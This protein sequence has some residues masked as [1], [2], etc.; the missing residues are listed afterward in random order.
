MYFLLQIKSWLL[1]PSFP[2]QNV[3]LR[4]LDLFLGLEPAKRS[5]GMP[6]TGGPCSGKSECGKCS[7]SLCFPPPSCICLLLSLVRMTGREK[8]AARFPVCVSVGG[9]R[10]GLAAMN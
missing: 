9:R 5:R 2:V 6:G 1:G 4:Y 3:S 8:E 10:R 7:G